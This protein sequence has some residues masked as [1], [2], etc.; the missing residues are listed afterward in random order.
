[1]KNVYHIFTHP[2]LEKSKV[3][4]DHVSKEIDA[5]RQ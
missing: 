5:L 3:N 4:K 1:M 2:N